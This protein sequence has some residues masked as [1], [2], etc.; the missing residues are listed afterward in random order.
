M[1]EEDGDKDEEDMRRELMGGGGGREVPVN[2]N[3]Y[4]SMSP[5]ER[6][7]ERVNPSISHHLQIFSNYNDSK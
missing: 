5:R 2:P 3:S 4:S 1:E 7:S 6:S